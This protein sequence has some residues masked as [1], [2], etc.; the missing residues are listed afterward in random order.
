[1]TGKLFSKVLIGRLFQRKL[2]ACFDLQNNCSSVRRNGAEFSGRLSC[3]PQHNV[4]D[5]VAAANK[6]HKVK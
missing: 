3:S 5:L 6:N 4:N 1:M 2:V